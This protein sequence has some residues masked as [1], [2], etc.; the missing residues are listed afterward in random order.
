MNFYDTLEEALISSDISLKERLT[1]ELFEYCSKNEFISSESFVP[2][3]FTK[4]SY[5]SLCTIVAP[6]EL[7]ARKKLN[8]DYGLATLIHAILHIEYSAIDLALDAVYRSLK[9][10][11]D[12]S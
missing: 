6:N 1:Q 5:A 11:K 10:L 8:T 12:I 3:R 2:E 4:P 9:C 7:K